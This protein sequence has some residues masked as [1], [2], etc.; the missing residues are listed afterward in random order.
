MSKPD[1]SQVGQLPSVACSGGSLL[2]VDVIFL[3]LK[4]SVILYFCGH[5]CSMSVILCVVLF[6]IF[7]S[8]VRVTC[9]P[10]SG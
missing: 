2:D 9:V 6:G 4:F 1:S 7:F 8:K 10:Y 5:R 3:F